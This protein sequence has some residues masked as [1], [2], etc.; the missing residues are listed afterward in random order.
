MIRH[1]NGRKGGRGGSGGRDAAEVPHEVAGKATG[2]PPPASAARLPRPD[3]AP[4]DRKQRSASGTAHLCA[5]TGTTP[6]KL[7]ED[8]KS[9][10][11][12]EAAASK[13]PSGLRSR[14]PSRRKR[15]R[16]EIDWH[17]ASR[18]RASTAPESSSAATISTT[19]VTSAEHETG[20]PVG[21]RSVAGATMS[22]K[23]LSGIQDFLGLHD[24]SSMP[25][26][27]PAESPA[28]SWSAD[29][30]E[31]GA[32]L[33]P[34]SV[35]DD[36]ERISRC[37]HSRR[38]H[39]PPEDELV[40][41]F[42]E[43][44]HRPFFDE[45]RAVD[46]DE[47]L[48]AYRVACMVNRLF[49]DQ[50]IEEQIKAFHRFGSVRQESLLLKGMR[51]SNDHINCLEEIF[52]KVQ[53]DVV[54][55]QYTFL[56]DDMA[57]S[58]GEMIEFYESAVKLNV[59]FNSEIKLRGWQAI[60]RAVKNNSCLEELN[61]RYTNVNDK[62]LS[63]M[64]RTFRTQPSLVSL[65]LEN[66]E[67]TGKKLLLL[68]CGLK[69]NTVLRELY[70]GDCGLMSTDGTHLYQLITANSSLQMVDLRHN[71]LGDEGFRHI[72]DALKHPDTISR[73][74]L[75]ALVMWNNGITS[76]SMD[77]LAQAL[78]N[79][80]KL[81]TL[82]IGKNG[83]SVDGVNA[84]KP[85]LQSG[86]CM[87]QRLG[88]QHT[89]L[90]CQSAIV[91][92]ECIADNDVLVRIDL[93]ENEGIASAGLLA[94]HLAMKM[95][96]SITSLD[97]DAS[98]TLSK[99]SKVVEYQE[100]FQLYYDEIQQFC[101]RNR[102]NALKKLSVQSTA[103][104]STV[105]VHEDS[106]AKKAETHE[107]KKET[108]SEVAPIDEEGE[109]PSPSS[110]EDFEVRP[111]KELEQIPLPTSKMSRRHKEKDLKK[112]HRS[113]SLTCTEMVE[114]L[115]ERVRQMRSSTSSLEE[116]IAESVAT[117]KKPLIIE[118]RPSISN[119]S[120][121]EWGRSPS[122]PD[123]PKSAEN[124]TTPPV[125]R[126]GRRFSVS[127]ST[128]EAA[129]YA[130]PSRFK[131]QAVPLKPTTLSLSPATAAQ[132]V[133][134]F[135]KASPLAECPA[136]SSMT[137]HSGDTPRGIIV[138]PSTSKAATALTVISATEVKESDDSIAKCVKA[139]VNDLVNYC[140][141]ELDDP[142][143]PPCGSPSL[144]RGANAA[145]KPRQPKEI[146]KE[147]PAVKESAADIEEAVR[148][149]MRHLVREILRGE[150]HEVAGK[151]QRKRSSMRRSKGSAS[152]AN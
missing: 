101:Q 61:M 14:V 66:V 143:K 90:N 68:T 99:N 108:K 110:S 146:L 118:S 59:S 79:N 138:L 132:K 140:V 45:N 34:S 96:T 4:E 35:V 128:S 55:F 54:D 3:S 73:S 95:N 135:L 136:G 141:Y 53:F 112:F 77:C 28:I 7:A 123:L 144:E 150:K 63:L 30:F 114:D 133:R 86:R 85:A 26:S 13:R 21:T 15:E 74:S 122:L 91:L 6:K 130:P 50:S 37:S 5:R 62:V 42:H 69:S 109:E 2:A 23:L 27:A 10:G 52:R 116:T 81:E 11:W 58:L 120:K 107:V 151:L 104:S 129:F 88:L 119:L 18:V 31:Q 57:V 29:A 67:L 121:S 83:L 93:R 12:L 65:H 94:L 139:V 111:S 152:L 124:G 115:N 44:V 148:D 70:L 51:M 103:S 87:L 49:P 32:I 41:G 40:S 47:I 8:K 33:T 64:A 25:D 97:L 82:N 105:S 48:N 106:D 16:R 19:T 9:R 134:A 102:Q 92:A 43:P 127:P 38:V 75:S 149:T 84:L 56:D 113:S 137:W 71:R 1:A 89:K 20:A 22:M 147:G 125:R 60:F 36:G 142:R 98:C 131:V 17:S 80:T 24:S 145:E 46:V 100:Q 39:F 117:I 78:M 72:C 126:A 76:A